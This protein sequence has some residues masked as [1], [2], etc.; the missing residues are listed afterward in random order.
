MFECRNLNQLRQIK[1]QRD[2]CCKFTAS[3]LLPEFKTQVGKYVFLPFALNRLT[4]FRTRTDL[5]TYSSPL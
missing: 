3:K 1:N 5:P 4:A 2:F